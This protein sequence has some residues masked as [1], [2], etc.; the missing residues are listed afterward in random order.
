[1]WPKALRYDDAGTWPPT[2]DSAKYLT[3]T[4]KFLF[5]MAPHDNTMLG[6]FPK[7]G[8]I[9]KVSEMSLSDLPLML[10]DVYRSVIGVV[11]TDPPAL[12]TA[13]LAAIIDEVIPFRFFLDSELSL[14]HT[15][16]FTP[17]VYINGS[18]SGSLFGISFAFRAL[19]NLRPVSYTHLTLPTKRI[20]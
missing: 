14:V 8:C 10:I 1:M 9:L 15:D 3:V 20:V 5:E 13:K 2:L 17:G 6:K 7:L 4:S 18:A 19:V 11:A 12:P 16:V